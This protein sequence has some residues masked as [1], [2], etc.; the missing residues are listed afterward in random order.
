MFAP[1][2]FDASITVFSLVIIFSYP[3]FPV[4]DSNEWKQADY[5]LLFFKERDFM[6]K[7]IAKLSFAYPC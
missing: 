6:N 4:R 3:R 7:E 1:R 5:I 2:F